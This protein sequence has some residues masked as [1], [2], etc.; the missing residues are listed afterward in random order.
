MHLR[1]GTLL[2]DFVVTADVGDK[3]YDIPA[4]PSGIFE[5]P[6]KFYHR[7]HRENELDKNNDSQAL[8]FLDLFIHL[9]IIKF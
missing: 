4:I 7:D 1:L 6:T 3:I 9:S 2:L 8:S 5:Q